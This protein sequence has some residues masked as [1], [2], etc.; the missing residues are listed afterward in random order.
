MF[1]R[2][3]V[4]LLALGAGAYRLATGAVL[5]GIGL[6]LMAGGLVSLQGAKARPSLKWLAFTC[7][8]LTG[9]IIAYVLWRNA[10]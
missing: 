7:F 9:G 10:Q 1:S 6:L 8:A 2:T 3:I 5:E 4:I